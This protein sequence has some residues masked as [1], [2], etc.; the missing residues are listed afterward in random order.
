LSPLA[1]SDEARF[2]RG[3]LIH[4]LF[5]FLPELPVDARRD[6][7]MAWLALPAHDLS[8]KQQAEILQS[9]FAVLE[10]PGFAHVFGPGARAEVPI[11]G[12]LGASIVS[13]QIDRLVVTDDSVLILDYKTNR[14]APTTPDAVSSTYKTQLR[15]YRDLL[16]KIWP[17]KDIRTALLWTDGPSLM[18]MTLDL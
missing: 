8:E 18:D 6:R 16:K 9:V 5:Q 11:T 17:D 3:R 13:G 14:P 2:K 15:L 1:G 12:M 4:T 7:A 10:R